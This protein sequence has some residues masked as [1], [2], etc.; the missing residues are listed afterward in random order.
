MGSRQLIAWS[1]VSLGSIALEQG[2]AAAARSLCREGLEAAAS[3]KPAMV[4]GIEL[5]ACLAVGEGEPVAA[6]RLFGAVE[7]AGKQSEWDRT[8]RERAILDRALAATR[9]ALGAEAFA[10][11]RAEG[12]AMSLEAAIQY[13]LEG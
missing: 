4:I 8:P 12:R 1:L 11:A 10:A 6:A 13:A 5:L 9:A 7:A 2:D 3:H